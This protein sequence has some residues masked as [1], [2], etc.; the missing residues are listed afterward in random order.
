[1]K[2]VH[3]TAAVPIVAAHTPFEDKVVVDTAVPGTA[4]AEEAGTVPVK[5]GT[6]LVPAGTAAVED[7]V[8]PAGIAAE[9]KAL[10]RTTAPAHN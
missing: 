7:T 9:D 8:V 2:P 10:G 1:M 6:V 3:P 5:V 4:L